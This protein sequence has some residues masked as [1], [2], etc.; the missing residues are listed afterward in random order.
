MRVRVDRAVAEGVIV[1]V[2]QSGLEIALLLVEQAFAVRDEVAQV[3]DLRRVD[4]G[5]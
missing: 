1:Q 5:E 2:L 4:G 3:P